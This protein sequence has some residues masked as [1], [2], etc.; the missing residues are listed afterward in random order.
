MATMEVRMEALVSGNDGA[1]LGRVWAMLLVRRAREIALVQ[2][3]V[4]GGAFERDSV[5]PF[6]L[7]VRSSG[8]Q[9]ELA[10]TKRAALADVAAAPPDGSVRLDRNDAVFAL[11]ARLGHLRGC[12]VEEAGA[13]SFLLINDELAHQLSLVSVRAIDALEPHR[14]QLGSRISALGELLRPSQAFYQPVELRS[15][16]ERAAHG[17]AVT[18]P[19]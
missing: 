5:V 19:D 2:L 4:A 14:I 16:A 7:L 6:A 3:L 13:V 11:D 12:Y 8:Q 1:T 15:D 18:G 17:H 9:I 10:V